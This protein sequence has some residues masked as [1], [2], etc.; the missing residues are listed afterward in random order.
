MTADVA[1]ETQRKAYVDEQARNGRT[2]AETEAYR[3]SA[4]MQALEGAD[5]RT[6][7]ALAA[8]G[9]QPGQLIAQAFGGLA[10]KAERIGQ[11][12]MSPELLNS[13]LGGPVAPP[14]RRSA[15]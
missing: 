4:V 15:V 2:L 11:L 13:L 7:Q 10:E 14:A 1:L 3:V 9:M 8:T 5:P 6:I 12:N